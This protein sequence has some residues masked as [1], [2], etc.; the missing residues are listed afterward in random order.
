ML[1][2]NQKLAAHLIRLTAGKIDPVKVL[3]D[4]SSLEAC[5]KIAQ[6]YGIRGCNGPPLTEKDAQI[7]AENDKVAIE[8]MRPYIACG[9]V[10]TFD[11]AGDPR[12]YVYAVYLAD[13]TRNTMG[14]GWGVD[15]R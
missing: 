6:R 11:H 7:E 10:R 1:P 12:G 2:E 5:A 9:A 15:Y 4:V 8:L 3:A 14:G 13:S